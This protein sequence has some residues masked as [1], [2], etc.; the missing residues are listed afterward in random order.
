VRI[1]AS[2]AAAG[3]YDAT[4]SP[5]VFAVGAGLL[6]AGSGAR[7]ET[8]AAPP[9]LQLSRGPGAERCP[10][11]EW[12]A[13]GV[14]QRLARNPGASRVPTT[15]QVSVTI[16]RTPDGFV[17]TIAAVGMAGGTRRLLDTGEDCAGLG[18]AL[19]LM[20]SMI[21]DGRPPP[22]TRSAA[23]PIVP[24]PE[25]PWELGAS[26][27]G[28]SSILGTPT[29]GAGLDLVWHPWPR[30]ATGLSAFW[31][32]TRGLAKGSGTS[33]FTAVAG[34]AK[35][36]WGIL[37][38]G[39]RAFPAVCALAGAGSLRGEGEG[40][41]QPRSVWVPWL[42]AGAALDLG[43]CLHRQ[44]SLAARAGYLLSLRSERFEVVGLEQVHDTSR[45][46]FLATIGVLVRIP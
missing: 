41:Q 15:E 12:L 4:V 27:V 5:W 23:P 43:L 13:T 37:P 39:D 42:V 11:A 20:L 26:A 8:P 30:I 18:E 2:R 3:G 19:L 34:M 31:L 24:A 36:C 17:A 14:A 45:P 7:A 21:A 40:Y 9:S 16:E 32:P 35:L 6:L 44:V 28:S 33:S 1:R 22:A 10:D 38:F 46:G 25:R 29:L